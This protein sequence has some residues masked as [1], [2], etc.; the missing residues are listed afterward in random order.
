ML[1]V[2]WRTPHHVECKRHTRRIRCGGSAHG[3][4]VSDDGSRAGI[5]VS[6]RS[7]DAE[8]DAGYENA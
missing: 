5:L 7:I 8:N 1:I 6:T 3:V 4:R 2:D